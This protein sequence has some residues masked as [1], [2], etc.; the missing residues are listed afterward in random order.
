LEKAL[1]FT[2]KKPRI[3]FGMDKMSLGVG[4]GVGSGVASA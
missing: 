4:S 1:I 3:F 2:T